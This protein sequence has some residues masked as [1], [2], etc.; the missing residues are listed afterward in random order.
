MAAEESEQW[1]HKILLPRAVDGQQ[2]K[3]EMCSG[4][5]DLKFTQTKKW[6]FSIA[7]K[8][9]KYEATHGRGATEKQRLG[10][11]QQQF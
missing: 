3:I 4:Q 10:L 9:S 5:D 8:G 1:L 2:G 11:T 6:L 7:R